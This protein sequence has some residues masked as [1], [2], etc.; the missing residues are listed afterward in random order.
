MH[1]PERSLGRWISVLYRLNHTLIGKEL[2]QYKIGK[3]QIP[4]LAYLYYEDGVSQDDLSRFLFMDKACTTRA[5]VKLEREGFITRERDSADGRVKRVFLTDKARGQERI[6]TSLL[7]RVGEVL[8]QGIE[9][10]EKDQVIALLK[11]M[12]GNMIGMLGR[13]KD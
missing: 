3:G 8:E 12:V 7:S 6:L 13:N 9:P 2:E 11:K 4:F 5:L 1:D 10:G